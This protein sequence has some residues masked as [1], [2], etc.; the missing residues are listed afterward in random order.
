M[1]PGDTGNGSE[2]R[3]SRVHVLEAARRA[4]NSCPHASQLHKGNERSSS[5]EETRA[6]WGLW[7]AARGYLV[8]AALQARK[9]KR[10]AVKQLA[11]Y[12]GKISGSI[13]STGPG[14]SGTSLGVECG[15]LEKGGGGWAGLDRLV[16]ALGKLTVLSP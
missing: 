16:L 12:T 15:A 9:P 1:A 14:P 13:P 11:Q 10:T 8:C 4:A 3:E 7:Q 6:G 5:I 2:M